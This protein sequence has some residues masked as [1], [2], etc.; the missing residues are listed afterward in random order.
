MVGG[1]DRAPR[2]PRQAVS[3]AKSPRFIGRAEGLLGFQPSKPVFAGLK[4]FDCPQLALKR[5]T[6][7]LFPQTVPLFHA[8]PWQPL[9]EALVSVRGSGRVVAVYEF[10]RHDF[11]VAEGAD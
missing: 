1:L 4:P 6:N 2:R 7:S 5:P 10:G 3:A 9:A 11:R 8:G